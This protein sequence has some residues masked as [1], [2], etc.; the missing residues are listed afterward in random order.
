M[1]QSDNS[2]INTPSST[3]NP[4]NSESLDKYYRESLENLRRRLPEAARV[5]REAGLHV[6]ESITTAAA[7]RGRLNRS[8]TSA[9]TAQNSI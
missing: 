8:D 4:V 1:T 9:L 2:S 7:T 3:L 5:L 6:S